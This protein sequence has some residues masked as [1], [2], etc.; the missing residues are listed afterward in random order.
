MLGARALF[1]VRAWAWDVAPSV[2]W[3]PREDS[4]FERD[5]TSSEYDTVAG[6]DPAARIAAMRRKAAPL[7]ALLSDKRCRSV[8]DIGCGAGAFFHVLRE[9]MPH[10]EYRGIDISGAQ[11]RRARENFGE[12][13]AQ[14]DAARLSAAELKAYDAVHINSVF[15]FMAI[16]K[17]L[18]LLAAILESGAWSVF[19]IGATLPHI[20]FVPS[21][22]FA[23]HAL[24]GEK[25]YTALA[26]P[27]RSQIDGVLARFAG[28]YEVLWSESEVA[29]KNKL[30]SVDRDGT[31]VPQ[32]GARRRLRR[33]L[34]D[35]I[36]PAAPRH[37]ILR[38]SVKPRGW[39]LPADDAGAQASP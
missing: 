9:T 25:R 30:C 33:R 1:H 16:P 15:A 6:S 14:A 4:Y 35:W 31:A 10:V 27:Y 23:N 13:F 8:L 38:G 37:R 17:Q 5:A 29:A 18:R 22:C 21:R 24:R 7:L 3:L 26:W 39:A 12:H 19:R 2:A 32:A 28:R 34:G 11:I 20:G 36:L